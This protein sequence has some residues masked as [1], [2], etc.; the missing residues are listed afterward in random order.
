M[1]MLP[2]IGGSLL[3][4]SETAALVHDL[5]P[6]GDDSRLAHALQSRAAAN[7]EELDVSAMEIA[8]ARRL[9]PLDQVEEIADLKFGA[10]PQPPREPAPAR[11]QEG[12]FYR[13]PSTQT[14]EPGFPWL[15][16]F[17]GFGTLLAAAGAGAAASSTLLPG[18]VDPDSVR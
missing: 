18:R 3:F 17:I 4:G 15:W 12:A 16:G 13:A 14:P 11:H 8:Q 1:V 2:V 9:G 6:E 5:A 7:G 10:R